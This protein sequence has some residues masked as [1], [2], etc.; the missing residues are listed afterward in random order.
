[1]KILDDA[2]QSTHT[3]YIVDEFALT[4]WS[5]QCFKRA[6]R[7]RLKSEGLD[8]TDTLFVPPLWANKIY[9]MVD[10]GPQG[11]QEASGV[12]LGLWK[13]H[14]YDVQALPARILVLDRHWE[15]KSRWVVHRYDS[16]VA[17]IHPTLT[18]ISSFCLRRF[19]MT[20]YESYRNEFM[21]TD[22]VSQ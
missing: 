16:K 11:I 8:E 1:M 6:I 20:T 9:L 14:S 5:L 19:R 17:L 3:D 10:E 21:E 15:S 4:I 7:I 22:T 13:H 12:I 2:L 18:C